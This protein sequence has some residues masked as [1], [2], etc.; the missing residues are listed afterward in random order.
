MLIIVRAQSVA[1]EISGNHVLTFM[2][3]GSMICWFVS[4]SGHIFRVLCVLALH[5]QSRC[6]RLQCFVRLSLSVPE[7]YVSTISVDGFSPN[8]RHWCILGQ[9]RTDYVLGQKSSRRGTALDTTIEFRFLVL[10]FLML[11]FCLSIVNDLK[12][13]VCCAAKS[14]EGQDRIVLEATSVYPAQ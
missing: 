10:S 3:V 6:R 13:T 12:F 14:D 1:M 7:Y 5:L 2:S 4:W 8:C 9:T 11:G